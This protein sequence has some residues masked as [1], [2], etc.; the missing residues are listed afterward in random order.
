MSV[1]PVRAKAAGVSCGEEGSAKDPAAA[2]N[3]E[4]AAMDVEEAAGKEAGG[5]SGAGGGGGE[6]ESAERQARES[7]G[8]VNTDKDGKEK[9]DG[10]RQE[11]P[12]S[13]GAG[14]ETMEGVQFRLS[15]TAT[16]GVPS[17]KLRYAFQKGPIDSLVSLKRDQVCM[18]KGP[19]RQLCCSQK[20]PA[21]ICIPRQHLPP[22]RLHT[23][24]AGA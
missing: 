7:L 24:P 21:C 2:G 11:R 13:D 5:G 16:R 1:Y 19:D 18:S 22:C 8:A 6:K 9:E 12:G 17:H 23:P 3:A 4:S 20:R 10:A 14:K 15:C